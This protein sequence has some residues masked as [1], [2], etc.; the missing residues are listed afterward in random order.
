[1]SFDVET[2]EY[3]L[4]AAPNA[5]EMFYPERRNHLNLSFERHITEMGHGSWERNK[6]VKKEKKQLR[7]SGRSNV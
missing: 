5:R 3:P 1:M 6:E 7:K 2:H 4:Y